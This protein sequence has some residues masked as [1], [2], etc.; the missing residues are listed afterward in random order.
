TK[1]LIFII[2]EFTTFYYHQFDLDRKAL[3]PLYRDESMLTF[4]T[5]SVKGAK[6]IVEKLGSLPFSKVKHDVATLD[7]QP[8]GAHGG[9]LILVT[10]RLLLEEEER[11]MSYTQVF[12]LIPDG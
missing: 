7:A 9:I 2:E 3:A 11:P 12:Q 6:D 10:G 4:E 8:S 5:T 1:K